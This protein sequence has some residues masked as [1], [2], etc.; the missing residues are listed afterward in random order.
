MATGLSTKDEDPKTGQKVSVCTY[1]PCRSL[2]CL[3]RYTTAPMVLRPN[4]YEAW[5]DDG[6]AADALLERAPASEE[7]AIVQVT[8]D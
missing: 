3:G 1:A 2:S 7:F 6:E 8:A 5:L 4:E